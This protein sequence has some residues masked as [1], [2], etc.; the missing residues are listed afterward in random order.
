MR[1]KIIPILLLLVSTFVF[2]ACQKSAAENTQIESQSLPTISPALSISP[3][4]APNLDS[5]IRKIDFENFSYPWT[6]NQGDGNFTLKNGK[7]ARVGEGDIEATLQKVEFGDV[8]NDGEEEAMLNIYPWSGGN[9]SCDM[10][11]I[12][13]LQNKTPKLLWS[14]D[15]WD[16]ADGGFKRAYAENS[17]LIVELFGDDKFENDEWEFDFPKGKVSGYCCPTAYTKIR[18]KWNGEKFTAQGTPELFDYDWKKEMKNKLE[19]EK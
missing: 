11:F 1:R 5:P 3:I 9:C 6:D 4:P 16:K 15:T 13:T 14:F 10:V 12:Y 19:K 7:K 2:S 18:F 17:E 8:T